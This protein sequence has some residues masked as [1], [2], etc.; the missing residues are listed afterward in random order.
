MRNKLYLYFCPIRIRIITMVWG[1][2]LLS[3][4]SLAFGFSDGK[5]ILL[6]ILCTLFCSP[7]VVLI[8]MPHFSMHVCL[9]FGSETFV[10]RDGYGK[11]KQIPFSKIEAIRFSEHSEEELGEFILR[12]VYT[13]T[14]EEIF[15]IAPFYKFGFFSL[16]E[17]RD[18]SRKVH[19]QQFKRFLVFE[20]TFNNLLVKAREETQNKV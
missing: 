12:V 8:T 20:D 6:T 15:H 13:S 18:A 11:K 17:E 19:E 1:I 10:F 7:C 5:A 9:N 16:L 4:P 2:F 3:T 14:E